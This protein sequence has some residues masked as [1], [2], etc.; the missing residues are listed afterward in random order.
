MLAGLDRGAVHQVRAVDAQET[1]RTG[2]QPGGVRCGAP[3]HAVGD[4]PPRDA[5]VLARVLAE[6][7]GDAK[8]PEG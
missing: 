8:R 2:R 4:E 5:E 3:A 1:P 7:A 6:R